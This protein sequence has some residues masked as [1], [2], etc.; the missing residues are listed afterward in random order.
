M[1]SMILMI[2]KIFAIDVSSIIKFYY[3]LAVLI[4]LLFSLMDYKKIFIDELRLFALC[5]RKLNESEKEIIDLRA[6]IEVLTRQMGAHKEI[7]KQKNLEI[8][9]AK[10]ETSLAKR[11]AGSAKR[12]A[13]A[14]EN[15]VVNLN[16]RIDNLKDKNKRL[17]KSSKEA[18]KLTKEKNKLEKEVKYQA[19]LKAKYSK[20]L[21][22]IKRKKKEDKELL[23]V[24]KDGGSVHRPKCIAVRNVPKENRILIKNWKLAQKENY[25][26]CGLCKPHIKSEVIVRK[27]VKFKFVGSK[28]SDKVHK[29]SCV[30][31]KKID[32][33][34]RQYFRTYKVALKKKFTA[35]RVCNPEQ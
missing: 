16:K 11:E 19:N 35:C 9:N 31:I 27:G 17:V 30:L 22:T 10:K 28:T 25:K 29:A 24:S 33:K 18:I 8:A 2:Y 21:S 26:G 1:T 7:I 32:E 4:A 14:N 3:V 23:V 12:S 15:K 34:D 6:S 13:T 20:T 5:K